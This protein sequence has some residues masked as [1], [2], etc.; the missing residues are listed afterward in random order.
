MTYFPQTLRKEMILD[1]Y[2]YDS[3]GPPHLPNVLPISVPPWN[4]KVEKI[5]IPILT[6]SYRVLSMWLLTL[7]LKSETQPPRSQPSFLTCLSRNSRASFSMWP[8]YKFVVRLMRPILERPKSVSLMCPMDVIRR[9]GNQ[10]HKYGVISWSTD[11]SICQ[12]VPLSLLQAPVGHNR[13]AS[14]GRQAAMKEKISLA[15]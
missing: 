5:G 1:L 2:P 6:S 11:F 12:I 14:E 3:C 8:S 15:S 4:Q 7:I 9:L 13:V 10:T